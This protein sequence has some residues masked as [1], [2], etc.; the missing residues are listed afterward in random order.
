MPKKMNAD[1]IKRSESR[2]TMLE[3]YREHIEQS[4][5]LKDG[6]QPCNPN[7]NVVSLSNSDGMPFIANNSSGI[8]IRFLDRKISRDKK[9]D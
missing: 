8:D 1:G 5:V 7:R 3:R 4:G 6:T 2:A 9:G